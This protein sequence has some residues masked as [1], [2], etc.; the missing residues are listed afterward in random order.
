MF[1]DT[2]YYIVNVPFIKSGFVRYYDVMFYFDH[3]DV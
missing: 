3:P 1:L 2:I